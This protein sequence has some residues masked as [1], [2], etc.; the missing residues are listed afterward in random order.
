[1][2]YCKRTAKGMSREKSKKIS[3]VRF[4]KRMTDYSSA[5]DC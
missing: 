5:T 1:M 2:K 3:T 4:Y